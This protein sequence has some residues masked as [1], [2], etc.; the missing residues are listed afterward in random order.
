MR[1]L[2]VLLSLASLALVLSFASG[3]DTSSAGTEEPTP[4]PA[5]QVEEEVA[6]ETTAFAVPT[7]ENFTPAPVEMGRPSE[8]SCPGE[9]DISR[10]SSFFDCTLEAC[11]QWCAEEGASFASNFAWILPASGGLCICSCC[12]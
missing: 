9:F 11:H 10:P 1:R 2:A 8:E 7:A 3:A 12:P 5:P 4:D 6:V